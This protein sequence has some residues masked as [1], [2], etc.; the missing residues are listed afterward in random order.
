VVGLLI[1]DAQFAGLCR[2][3]RRPDLAQ[4]PRFSEMVKRFENW[5]QLVPLLDAEVRKFSSE[6]FLRRARA[7][8]APFAPVNDLDEFLNDPQ[9]LHRKSVVELIDPRFGPVKYLS[10]PV[11]FERTPASIQRHAPRLGEHTDEVLRELGL[12]AAKLG[13]L[14]E[15]GAIR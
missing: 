14:R 10:P 3:I 1:Q 15:S 9:V 5:L 11:R 2:V 6:E 4:D 13:A 7:E 12:D 8:G